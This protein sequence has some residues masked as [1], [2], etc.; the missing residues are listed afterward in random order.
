MLLVRLPC[1]D[2]ARRADPISAAGTK[3]LI[4]E[5]RRIVMMIACMSESWRALAGN[6]TALHAGDDQC[7]C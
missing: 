4:A 3:V 2:P 1:P 5:R 6:A 7:R